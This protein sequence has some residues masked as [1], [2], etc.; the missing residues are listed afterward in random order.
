MSLFG[1]GFVIAGLLFLAGLVFP[2]ARVED[3]VDKTL[4]FLTG[5][6]FVFAGIAKIAGVENQPLTVGVTAILLIVTVP[7]YGY[8]IFVRG[9]T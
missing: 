2:S 7:L 6:F 5:F 3:W 9:T 1:V 4:L 8:Q